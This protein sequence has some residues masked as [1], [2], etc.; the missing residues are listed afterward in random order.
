M[1]NAHQVELSNFPVFSD[2]FQM[3]VDR[4]GYRDLRSRFLPIV[5]SLGAAP[6]VDVPSEERGIW[7]L[8]TGGTFVAKRFG[9]VAAIGA[10]GQFLAALRAASMLGEMLATLGSEPHKVTVLDA[11]MD[12][13]V[14]APPVV[15]EFYRRAT[16]PQQG[17]RLTRKK[18]LATQVTKVF[19][20]RADGRESG[21]VY[22]GSRYADVRLKVYDKQHERFFHGVEAGP[23]VRYE[24]TLKGGQVSLRDVYEPSGVFWAHM[25]N[26]LPRPASAPNWLVGDTGY[27]LPRREVPSP[28]ERL[29]ARIAGSADLAELVD[30]A[31]SLPG[32]RGVLLDELCR[33][34]P[35]RPQSLN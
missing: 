19:G 15:H 22:L 18:V 3:T 30:L 26:V 25:Q 6:D 4:M 14:D 34:Y 13:P 28:L 2:R 17:Y 20:Q 33:A 11:T 7:K 29:R 35:A 32:G 16:D 8:A 24:L 1:D 10:S 21:T 9:A 23:G 27:R 5:Q 12:V 31:D